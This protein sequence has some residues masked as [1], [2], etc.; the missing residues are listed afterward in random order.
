MKEKAFKETVDWY[1]SRFSQFESGLNGESRSAIHQLRQ[2]A[3]EKF[4]QLGFPTTR[5]EEWKYTNVSDLAKTEFSPTQAGTAIT[6]IPEHY[7]AGLPE[8]HTLVFVDG[9][10]NAE[11]SDINDIQPGLQIGSLAE[12]LAKGQPGIQSFLTHNAEF[13]KDGFTALSTAFLQ[14][15]AFIHISNDIE[16]QKPVHLLF[17]TSAGEKNRI[18]QP[19]ILIVAERNARATI[20]E[21]WKSTGTQKYFNNIVS[22]I[23]I[24]EN[25]AINHVKIQDENESAYH[26]S[27]TYVKQSRDS[28]FHNTSVSFGA[29]LAR[30]NITAMLDAEG[31]T[32][33]L[34]GVYIADGQQHMDTHTTIH[35]A[36]PHCESNEMYKGILDGKA[37]GVFN[38]KIYV[39]PDAQ[40]TNAM[41]GNHTM[42][43]SDEATIDTKPQLEIYADD[44]RCTH[45]ATIGQ[46][47]NDAYFYM[48]ARGL[49]AKQ[50]RQLLLYAF[51]SE[52]VEEIKPKGLREH[53]SALM[54]EKM[55][56]VQPL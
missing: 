3:I 56:T 39:H 7:K 1:R 55:H 33:T 48:R 12:G 24:N 6:G 16:V 31:I 5:N 32:T 23:V 11:L 42:L 27:S 28:H 22:E 36:K 52:V 34:N 8:A 20:V 46:L 44:V 47:D 50:A 49:G 14:D 51:A 45:G 9:R 19:R 26:I 2:S 53:I 13:E 29:N 37:H 18:I 15:G 54:S 30:N 40:K 21:S 25:A 38:G 43:L 4:S 41:Q 35:H 10:F 17:V